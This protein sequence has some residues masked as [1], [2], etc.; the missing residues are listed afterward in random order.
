MFP[1][2]YMLSWLKCPFVYSCSYSRSIR[3]RSDNGIG[4]GGWRRALVIDVPPHPKKE[5]EYYEENDRYE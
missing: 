2:D 3:I 5:V 1:V 4:I